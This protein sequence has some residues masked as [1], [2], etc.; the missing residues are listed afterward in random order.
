MPVGSWSGN[1]EKLVRSRRVLA[2]SSAQK[3]HFVEKCPLSRA[4]QRSSRLQSRCD[5]EGGLYACTV[6][7][8][9]S[10]RVPFLASKPSTAEQ[11]MAWPRFKPSAKTS[12]LAARPRLLST[13]TPAF[14][15]VFQSARYTPTIKSQTPTSHSSSAHTLLLRAGFL[16]QSSTGIWNFLPNAIRVLDK[17]D[18]IVREEMQAIGENV[19]SKKKKKG[20]HSL[21][22]P[23]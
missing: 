15:P 5:V 6:L 8:V 4:F 13:A 14:E 18:K 19:W 12:P 22:G 9:L 17:L 10:S 3:T 11:T 23:C 16:R 7:Y 1:G 2:C 20:W 21:I